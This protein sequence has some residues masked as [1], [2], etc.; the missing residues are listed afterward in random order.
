MSDKVKELTVENF[1]EAIKTAKYILSNLDSE[2]SAAEDIIERAAAGLEKLAEQKMAEVK[3][4]LGSRG[5]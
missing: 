4:K 3:G 5:Q 2:S 1:D